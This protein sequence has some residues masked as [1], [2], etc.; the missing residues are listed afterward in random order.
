MEAVTR[1]F[2][3]SPAPAKR[4][5]RWSAKRLGKKLDRLQFA[6]VDCLAAILADNEVKPADRISAAKLTFDIVKSR[7]A[8]GPESGESELHVIFDGIPHEYAE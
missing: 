6:A 7:G 5:G 1:L 2:T 3:G 4:V 8:S